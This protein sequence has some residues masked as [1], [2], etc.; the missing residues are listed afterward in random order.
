LSRV[1][2]HPPRERLTPRSSA[3]TAGEGRRRVPPTG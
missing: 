2:H 3:G 1:S